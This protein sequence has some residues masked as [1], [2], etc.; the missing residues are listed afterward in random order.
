[1]EKMKDLAYY[2]ARSEKIP[3]WTRGDEASALAEAAYALDDDAVIVEIGS[4][5]GGSAV[6]MAGARKLKGSGKV[7]CID[8]FDGSG[9]RFSTPYYS[10]I[11]AGTPDRS[12]REHFDRNIRLAGLARWV[13]VHPG[14]AVEIAANWTTPVDM[15]FF[16]GD[17]SPAGVRAA[18]EAWSPWLKPGGTIAL[19][20]SNPRE[21]DPDHMGHFLIAESEIQQPRYT[22]RCLVAST[23]FAR[24]GKPPGTL[25][26]GQ[27]VNQKG[28]KLTSAEKGRLQIM[29]PAY[30]PPFNQFQRALAFS[31]NGDTVTMSKEI[32]Q[33]LVSGL[34]QAAGFDAKWYRW[35]YP[36]VASAI[37]RGEVAGELAH[38]VQVGYELGQFHAPM[39][40]DDNWYETNYPDVGQ[41]IADGQ[42]DNAQ[43][44][45]RGFGYFEGRAMDAESEIEAQRWNAAIDLSADL[46]N[47]AHD[48]SAGLEDPAAAVRLGYS[49]S[50]QFPENHALTPHDEPRNRLEQ[51]FDAKTQGHGIWKWR[52]YFDIYDRHFRRFVDTEVNIL[53]IGVYSGGSLEMWRNYFGPKAKI[54]GVDIEESCRSYSGDGVEVFIGDQEDRNFWSDFKQRVPALDLVIDDGGHQAIQQLVTLEELLPHLRPGGVYL[55]EDLHGGMHSFV[56]YIHGLSHKLN[57]AEGTFGDEND[58][59]RRLGCLA[60]SFQEA[61][62]S[63]HLYPFIAVIERNR[64]PVKELVAPKHGS[65]WQPFL[66]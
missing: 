18:Y 34:A 22:E 46:V 15:L 44:H 17:Q 28:S 23:T 50:Y 43:Q 10:E 37:N 13:Q 59:E 25:R 63:I 27:L 39:V 32:F 21:Y 33:L 49:S 16:D 3:G 24:K 26:Q 36:E 55:C 1:M 65:I 57:D 53:E 19:H 5:F 8:P 48:D 7:H 29:T 20:N 61:V 2:L 66:R 4:F 12:P 38:F 9:D 58:P 47:A 42:V 41:S 60:S 30:L 40:V 35:E 62:G 6:I 52:H 54:Y 56:A 31:A 14:T 64:W 51:F 11:I 45:Y